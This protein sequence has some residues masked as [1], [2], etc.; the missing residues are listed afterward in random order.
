VTIFYIAVLLGVVTGVVYVACVL[1]SFR[2]ARRELLAD[3][4]VPSGVPSTTRST[5]YKYAWKA[6]GGVGMSTFI[7]VML[8]VSPTAWSLVP[9]LA[10][11]SSIAV[12]TAFFI[13]H[14]E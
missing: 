13:D 11:G 14:K 10:I 2:Q 5:D 6:L 4:A 8:S 9:F 1:R 12:I 3:S 7:V